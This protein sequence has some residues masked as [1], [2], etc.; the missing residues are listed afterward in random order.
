M[1]NKKYVALALGC[2]LLGLWLPFNSSLM[3][4]PGGPWQ[5]AVGLCLWLASAAFLSINVD[6]ESPLQ[7]IGGIAVCAIGFMLG[8]MPIGLLGSLEY[9]ASDTRIGVTIAAA[10]IFMVTAVHL[11]RQQPRNPYGPRRITH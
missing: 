2:A 8:A 3:T 7:T 4:D 1:K 10:A 11:Y 9:M 5:I 6:P